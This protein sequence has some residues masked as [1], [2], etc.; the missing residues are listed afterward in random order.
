LPHFVFPPSKV[1]LEFWRASKMGFQTNFLSKKP[2]ASENVIS[3]NIV[4]IAQ[5]YFKENHITNI[6]FQKKR[7]AGL[8]FYRN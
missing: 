7:Q 3:T 2:A 1:P 4:C 5:R 6:A 8:V